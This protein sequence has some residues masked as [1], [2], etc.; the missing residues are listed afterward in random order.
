M[1]SCP[2]NH[3]PRHRH[4]SHTEKENNCFYLI[5]FCTHRSN[6]DHAIAFLKRIRSKRILF[7]THRSNIVL[8][9]NVIGWRM[10]I[11]WHPRYLIKRPGGR[12]MIGIQSI[13]DQRISNVEIQLR[14][15]DI[16]NS[17]K[18]VNFSPSITNMVSAGYPGLTWWRIFTEIWDHSSLPTDSSISRMLISRSHHYFLEILVAVFFHGDMESFIKI[19]VLTIRV[20]EYGQVLS[21][22]RKIRR[23]VQRMDQ[24]WIKQ[25]KHEGPKLELSRSW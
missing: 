24:R 20:F 14:T 16:Q 17:H 19:F 22:Q 8:V 4:Q 11:F 18:K 25:L 12:V 6:I 7:C 15:S 3:V 13:T 1:H 2:R 21:R 10:K 9:R 5:L 23:M